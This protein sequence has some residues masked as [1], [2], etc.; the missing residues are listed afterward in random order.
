MDA[1]TYILCRGYVKK[2]AAALGA[3]KGAPCTIKSITETTGG[4]TVTFEWTGDNDVKQTSTMFVADGA[5]GATGADGVSVVSVT[6]NSSGHL[7][8]TLSDGTTIDAGEIATSAKTESAITTNIA[9]GGVK[10]GKT[11]SAGTDLEDIITDMLVEYKLPDAS[12]SIDPATRLY[13]AVTGSIEEIEMTVVATKTTNAITKIVFYVNDQAVQEIT[14]GVADGGTFSYTYTPE[15]PIT[16]N[17]NFAV[18]VFDDQNHTA[19]R[20]IAVQFAGKTYYGIV[21]ANVVEPT[22]AQIKAL[23]STLKTTKEYTY[24]N[25]S[26]PYG[27]VVYTYPKS[28]GAITT[29]TDLA[30]GINYENSF[31]L[32]EKQVDGIDY[33]VYTQTDPSAAENMKL[34]FA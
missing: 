11:Y 32:T 9:V 15:T 13:D 3:V 19:A 21:D 26:T 18:D 8:T 25:V 1:A 27:K 17:V 33:Y 16:T 23:N 14:N 31:T 12:L 20:L 24:N 28:F 29:I 4:H 6:V 34:R 5:T 7:I 30:Y 22:E 2:T 10:S